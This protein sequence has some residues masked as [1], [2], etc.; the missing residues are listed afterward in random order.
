MRVIDGRFFRNV[1]RIDESEGCV[2]S[3]L[4]CSDWAPCLDVVMAKDS[5]DGRGGVVLA[6]FELS[7]AYA[8]SYGSKKKLKDKRH[9]A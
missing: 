7:L 4:C 6:R 1:C 3:L 2:A 9:M 5:M 8:K